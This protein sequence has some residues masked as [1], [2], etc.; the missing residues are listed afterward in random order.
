[1]NAAKALDL[2]SARS[3]VSSYSGPNTP[4]GRHVPA[5]SAGSEERDL[6]R[7]GQS[8][9]TSQSASPAAMLAVE[10]TD[11]VALLCTMLADRGLKLPKGRNHPAQLMRFLISNGILQVRPLLPFLCVAT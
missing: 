7:A 6:I 5:G 10:Y 9:S 3:S 1:M 2:S 8:C 4:A 11:E